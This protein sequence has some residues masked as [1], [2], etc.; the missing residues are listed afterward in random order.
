[1]WPPIP[2]MFDPEEMEKLA[3]QAKIEE[4]RSRTW[5]GLVLLMSRRVTLWLDAYPE[6]EVEAGTL[7]LYEECRPAI[8]GCKQVFEWPARAGVKEYT[9]ARGIRHT[10][11][12]LTLVFESNKLRDQ[13]A[14]AQKALSAL[15]KI[16]GAKTYTTVPGTFLDAAALAAMEMYG[17]VEEHWG[18][19]L[20]FFVPLETRIVREV[21][22][23]YKA[24][25]SSSRPVSECILEEEASRMC[26][27]HNAQEEDALDAGLR[28]QGWPRDWDPAQNER[29]RYPA[30]RWN[31]IGGYQ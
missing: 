28:P 11:R 14:L 3:L 30:R 27:R 8:R 21:S 17:H 31:Y 7:R 23:R 16:P 19:S 22:R 18:S 6:R 13:M 1:L 4:L 10:L 26:L 29:P 15:A 24:P 5:S 25:G 9:V 2:L 12:E 20:E